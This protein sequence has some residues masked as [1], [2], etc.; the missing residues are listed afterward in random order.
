MKHQSFEIEVDHGII[1]ATDEEVLP[2]KGRGLLTIIAPAA[3]FNSLPPLRAFERA[4]ASV[5]ADQIA[6]AN[7]KTLIDSSWGRNAA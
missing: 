2:S 7:W 4:Q 1:R 6:V 5:L 3:S